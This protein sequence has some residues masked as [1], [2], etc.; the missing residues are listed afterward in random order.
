MNN[1]SNS[2][3]RHVLLAGTSLLTLAGCS[4]LIDI[5]PKNDPAQ[6][7]A[8]SANLQASAG[9]LH[10]PWQL[11][12][13]KPQASDSLTTD[14]IAIRR[15]DVMDYYADAQWTDA[16]PEL[17]QNILVEALEKNGAISSVA[18]DAA[19]IHADFILNTELRAFEARYD[20]GDAAPV[21][22]VDLTVKLVAAKSAEIL[23]AQEFHQEQPASANSVAAAVAAFDQAVAAA[24]T[25]IVRWVLEKAAHQAR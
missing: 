6:I 1:T 17:L 4:H 22:V 3:R 5:G 21:I 2:T 11:A 7:Y 19:G 23:A 13:A 14:R 8:L 16:V 9:A 18:S 15:G 12:V 25:D 20:H 24:V 10:L